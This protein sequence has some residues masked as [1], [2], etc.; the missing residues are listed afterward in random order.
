M[1]SRAH[2]SPWEIFR[3]QAMSHVYRIRTASLTFSAFPQR[4]DG[5][6]RFYL[7]LSVESELLGDFETWLIPA[8]A[9]SVQL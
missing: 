9:L 3:S 8:S 5:V 4:R 2:R 1:V 7:H 6:G